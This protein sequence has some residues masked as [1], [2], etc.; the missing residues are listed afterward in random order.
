MNGCESRECFEL[1]ESFATHSNIYKCAFIARVFP[2]K[3]EKGFEG[4]FLN[5][6]TFSINNTRVFICVYYIYIRM[7]V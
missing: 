4:G 6:F 3:I 5:F 1:L 7:L 2:M